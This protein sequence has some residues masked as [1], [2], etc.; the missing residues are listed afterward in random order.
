MVWQA[1]DG[2]AILD[3]HHSSPCKVVLQ[4]QNRETPHADIQGIE[5]EMWLDRADVDHNWVVHWQDKDNYLGFHL[6]NNVIYPEKYINGQ[7]YRVTPEYDRFSFQPHT[8]YR[9]K[10][11]HSLSRHQVTVSVNGV[12]TMTFHE[13]VAD[14]QNT[15]PPGLAGSVGAAR[16]FSYSEYDS[17]R[18]YTATDVLPTTLNVPLVKQTEPQWSEIEY[19]QASSWSPQEMGI[20]RWGCALTSAVMVFRYFGL[21]T[22][23]DGTAL[24][25][26]S[27]N[28]WLQKQSDGY[29]G[30]GLLNWRALGRL[31]QEIAESLG[32]PTLEMSFMAK[33][34]TFQ[35][36]LWQLLA[37]NIP[38]ILSIP[39]HFVVAHGVKDNENMLV[40]DPGYAITTRPLNKVLSARVFTPSHTD[41]SALILYVPVG[42]QVQT[43]QTWTRVLEKTPSGQQTYQIFDLAK[44]TESLYTIKLRNP[45]VMS[46]SYFL[47]AY[48]QT[49]QVLKRTEVLPAQTHNREITVSRSEQ[50]DWQITANETAWPELSRRELSQFLHHGTLRS[51]WISEGILQNQ[52]FLKK[53]THL[54]EAEQVLSHFQAQYQRYQ[55]QKWLEQEVYELIWLHHQQ[56]LRSLFP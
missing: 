20:G 37:E 38:P 49:G 51:P 35:D 8:R 10:L 7:A 33:N 52:S 12:T 4:P 45:G 14:P 50:A 39:D 47:L 42:L 36:Q 43:D 32:T 53:Q 23:T 40:R 28:T 31:S 54:A 56:Q 19:D 16:D 17:V 13:Q 1:N 44:P 22:L 46:S 25:P 9:V 21:N 24:T 6:F 27:V 2:R 11:E 15:G 55:A 29:L 3:I 41:L 18:L 34:A 30:E 5:F 48:D 26:A